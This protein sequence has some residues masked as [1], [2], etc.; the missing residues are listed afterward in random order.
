MSSLRRAG[1]VEAVLFDYGLT[2]VH[3]ERPVEEVE[4]AQ[5]AIASRIEAAGHPRPD[6]AVLRAAVH[7]RVEAEVMAHETSG[8]LEEVDVAAL[9]QRAFASIGLDLDAGLREQCSVLV[10]E[11]WW[12]GVRLYPDA[13]PALRMLRERG[14]RIG[15][16][17]NAAYHSASMHGQLAHV[18]LDALLDAAVFSGE[19]G[20]RKPSQRLFE[21]ALSALGVRAGATVF[22]GDRVREDIRGATKTGMRT[23]LIIRDGAGAQEE[24]AENAPGAVITSL[25]ELPALLLDESQ[26]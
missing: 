22:V 19:V 1:P 14:L 26:L 9:Q 18:G 20:W 5:V 21:A 11:A 13:R 6:V 12:H 4:A 23:V 8:A 7:D 2:L 3:F 10:Q 17:S 25:S 15:I 24:V 16:C